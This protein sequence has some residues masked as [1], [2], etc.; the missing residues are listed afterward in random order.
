MVCINL[1][2]L[3]NVNVLVGRS[4]VTFLY[5]TRRSVKAKCG[6]SA[7]FGLEAVLG[8]EVLRFQL[9]SG[10]KQLDC[11]SMVG[12]DDYLIY[13]KDYQNVI[14]ANKPSDNEEF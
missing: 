12:R 5:Y 11:I 1:G 14:T 3:F 8:N 2:R 9:L 13:F 7:V 6:L 4:A 10:F